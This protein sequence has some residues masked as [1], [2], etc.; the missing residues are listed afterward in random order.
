VLYVPAAV[1]S[2][3]AHLGDGDPLAWRAALRVFEQAFGRPVDVVEELDLDVVDPMHV[4]E[5][6]A[7]ERALLI[8]RVLE[9]HPH[10]AELVPLRLRPVAEVEEGHPLKAE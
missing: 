8:A 2:L 4:S 1:K 5:M 9:V 10:L 3:R 7:A 6:T